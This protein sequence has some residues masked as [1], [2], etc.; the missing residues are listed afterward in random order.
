M[1]APNHFPPAAA[2]PARV[3]EPVARH[4]HDTLRV[5]TWLTARERQQVDAANCGC[6]RFLHHDT[7]T[8]LGPDLA[9]GRAEAAL[10]S[11]ALIGRDT[12]GSV[13]ALVRGFPAHLVAALVSTAEEANVPAATFE[14]GRAGVRLVLDVRQSQG[15]TTF[16]RTLDPRRQRDAFM[17]TALATVLA[18]IGGQGATC[19]AFFRAAF[20]PRSRNATDVAR[21]CGV[22]P[23]TL[24]SRFHRA[25]LPSPKMYVSYARFVWAAHLGESPAVT[26]A[27]I[28]ERLRA[29]SPQ[30][31]SRTVRAVLGFS[32]SAFRT[33]Y[34]GRAMLQRYR[35]E[36][37]APYRQTLRTFD[38]LGD[39]GR[40]GERAEY[41]GREASREGRAA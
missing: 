39:A 26:I 5:T 21:V 41:Y 6:L 25:G 33:R 2:A 36:L 12:H 23:P 37:I 3:G 30:S 24:T 13:S 11:A 10:I 40:V 35:D 16:R 38:P 34:D 17:C 1:Y 8:A 15:W 9:S 18:D 31:F 27:D 19:A 14:L 22:R 32:P 29:S 4:P 28:A 20:A 7:V